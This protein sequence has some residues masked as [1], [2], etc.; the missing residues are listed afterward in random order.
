MGT[1]GIIAIIGLFMVL[2]ATIMYVYL[3][4]TQRILWGIA[5]LILPYIELLF[6]FFHWQRA[7][8][9]FVI[10]AIGHVAFYGAAFGGATEQFQD[11]LYEDKDDVWYSR[12]YT[13]EDIALY[14]QVRFG[15]F[16]PKPGALTPM[17]VEEQKRL[18]RLARER[19]AEQERRRRAELQRQEQER[20][21]A[22]Y[23]EHAE[24]R[25]RFEERRR[26]EASWEEGAGNA[27][28][29]FLDNAKSV[30]WYR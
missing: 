16:E 27:R 9:A 22:R 8:A 15:R 6:T 28:N 17:E 30:D 29:A 23:A 14:D 11:Y 2:L 1:L 25:A 21:H 5:V 3:A 26:A 4:F 7:R 10:Y 19:R 24:T 20:L 13:I 12:G 18:E